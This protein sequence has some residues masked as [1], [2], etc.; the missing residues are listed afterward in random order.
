MPE[1]TVAGALELAEQFKAAGKRAEAEHLL[2]QVA[3]VVPR[4][5]AIL[6]RLGICV[7]ESGR[8]AEARDIFQRAVQL[9]PNSAPGWQNLSLA[10]ER[11]GDF[12]SAITARQ[13]AIEI[14]PNNS[15]DRHRLGTCFGKKGDYAAS[16]EHL[17]KAVELA[18]NANGPIHDLVLALSRDGQPDPA[19]EAAFGR[20]NAIKTV[21]AE[22]LRPVADA[23]K[24]SGR[25]DRATKLWRRAVD[26]DPRCFECQGQLAMCLITVGDYLNGWRY[27]ECRW[28]CDTFHGNT[29]A[30][31]ARQWGGEILGHPDV[32]GKTILIYSEQGIGDMI[33][34]VR[35]ASIFADRGARV[36]VQCHWPIKA[37]MERCTG[38]RLV[39]STLDKLPA[40]DWHIP[41]LSLPYAFQ[42][43]LETIPATVP[44]I[45]V[46]SA[47]RKSWS[48]RVDAV[49]PP[50][51]RRRVGIA[52]AGNPKHNNDLNRSIN[53]ALFAP[54]ADVENIAFF[55]L[56]KAN[57][58]EKAAKLPD[59]PKLIDFTSSLY[60]FAETAALIDRL[61]LVI[62]ADTAVC[63]LAGALGKPVWTLLPYVPDFR[64]G[65]TGTKTPWYPNMEL[66]RQPN[67]N[68]WPTVIQ[69]VVDAL[70]NPEKSPQAI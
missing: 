20:I 8:I 23:Y 19:E 31:P 67:P 36:I 48:A 32:A 14:K 43:T 6:E 28:N 29:R 40:Y 15:E 30:D 13:K 69:Q 12:D 44:Y 1:M 52:W 46:D 54:L 42:T 3:A 56:Q 11:L 41:V 50:G 4:N 45:T 16:I 34:F 18:P 64:W 5:S 61:D 66:F 26:A 33:Q 57:E 22:M 25:F 60:D 62:C 2:R 24:T 21:D 65:L 59:R 17:K 70:K 58:N 10:H 38:V 55:N 47:R 9:E 39:Y 27:Y 49:A 51:A 53:P 7:A 63:H 68:D 35:Y 37:L